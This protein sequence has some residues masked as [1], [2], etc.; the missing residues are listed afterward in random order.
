MDIFV[1]AHFFNVT[2]TYRRDSDIPFPYGGYWVEP[3]TAKRLGFAPENLPYD[4]ETILSGKS[5][6]IFWLVSNCFTKSRR[7]VA[8]EKL[9]Q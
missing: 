7:E 2:M 8:V 6:P 9:K 5:K 3:S 4:E 1:A